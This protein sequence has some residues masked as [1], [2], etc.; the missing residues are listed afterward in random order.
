MFKF[1][2]NKAA[3][4]YGAGKKGESLCQLLN[5]VGIEVLFVIDRNESL[6]GRTVLCG[7]V[8][9]VE[10]CG[11][12]RVPEMNKSD[13]VVICTMEN[14]LQHEDAAEMLYKNGYRNI[15]FLPVWHMENEKTKVLYEIYNSLINGEFDLERTWEIPSYD[16]LEQG[17]GQYCLYGRKWSVDGKRLKLYLP[18]ELL[19]SELVSADGLG[20]EQKKSSGIFG[21]TNV[22]SR[23]D[24]F[25]LWEYLRTG[26]GACEVYI[27]T[28]SKDGGLNKEEEKRLLTGRST[29]LRLYDKEFKKSDDKGFFFLSPASGYYNSEGKYINIRDGLHRITYLISRRE[30][31]VPVELKV[32]DY[33]ALG[34]EENLIKKT[35]AGKKRYYIEHPAFYL[36]NRTCSEDIRLF[37]FCIQKRCMHFRN[38][39]VF[40]L[41]EDGG[42]LLRNILRGGSRHVTYY[43][44]NSD[45]EWSETL[46]SFFGFPEEKYRIMGENEDFEEDIWDSG[47]VDLL[48]MDE[49]KIRL[50]KIV[51]LKI[52]KIYL[53]VRE[54]ACN[55]IKEKEEVEEIERYWAGD[56]MAV[57]LLLERTDN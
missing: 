52:R 29:L 31:E 17:E 56:A 42:Y 48:Y 11:I 40:I 8:H 7:N 6:W 54:E 12:S 23:Y 46:M 51:G 20:A 43:T 21:N 49:W 34:N 37:L 4:I 36:H 44:F 24:Y 53:R 28:H 50:E 32:E 41:A 30:W 38:K 47:I 39:N 18:V 45:V 33:E 15:I 1:H 57:T 13:I 16:E 22:I 2:K 25:D 10:I 35:L 19:Y 26:K 3:I 27:K 5:K 14:A 55:A 9:P